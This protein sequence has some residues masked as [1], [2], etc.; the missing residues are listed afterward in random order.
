MTRKLLRSSIWLL[1][2]CHAAAAHASPTRSFVVDGVS[3]LSEGKLDGTS[4]T[5]DG[6]IVSGGQTRRTELPGVLTAKSLLVL[7]DGSALVGTGNDGKIYAYRDGAARVFAETK[8]LMVASL[9]RDAN[10]TVY[11]GTL[12]SGKIFAISKA[13]QVREFAAPPDAE[14]IWALAFDERQKTLYAATGPH[15]KLFAIDAK[16]KA[17]LYYDSEDAH[18]MA[19]ARADDGSLY[20]GT[21]DRALVLRLRGVGRAE[22]LYDFDGSEITALA[23]S[24]SQLAVVANQFAK[25]PTPIKPPMPDPHGAPGQPPSAPPALDRPQAGKGLLYR[26]AATGQVERLFSADEGHLTSVMWLDADTLYVGTGKEG[27]L[28]R[29]RVSDHDHSLLADVDERQILALARAGNKTLFVTGDSAAIYELEAAARERREW[30]SKVLDAGARARFGRV[31]ARGRG[32]FTLRTR[33]GNTDKA[34]NT[35][36]GWSALGADQSVQSP[37]ARFLQLQV[38]L[39]EPSS[40]VYGLEAFYLPDNQP[41]LVTEVNVEPP[42][43]RTER[44]GGRPAPISSA[45]KLRWKVDNPDN[46]SLRYRLFFAGEGAQTYVR[47]LR[48]GAVLTDSEFTWETESVPDGYYR[49]RVEVSD[50]LDNPEPLALK[51]DRDSEPFL[52]DNRAPELPEL[53]VDSA[54]R[55]LVGKAV[56]ALGPISK[57]EYNVDG[58]EWRLLRVAG[59][60]LDSREERFALPLSQLPKG[61]HVVAVRASDARGNVATRSITLNV[62]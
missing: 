60:L 15:G 41:A 58:L 28:H 23:L 39:A 62:Q 36:S 61:T 24:G 13:G 32:P 55:E 22:V 6:S 10:G 9:A 57:L 53:Q 49:V 54:R 47:M 29:V 33:S 19:L 31:Q 42:R 16:G 51:T 46:D 3:A 38:Q 52:V 37:S 8:Q 5:S 40:V 18:I 50:E 56:D 26:I 43:P 34:D 25:A 14:H 7:P 20:I 2:A 35:W 30:T 4:V 48:E 21:S 59:D 17:E 44:P 11:A 1:V 45:Y 27:H 12:P